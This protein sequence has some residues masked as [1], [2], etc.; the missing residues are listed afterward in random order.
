M[1]NAKIRG[2]DVWADLGEQGH[3]TKQDIQ[4]S[5]FYSKVHN[6]FAYLPH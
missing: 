1:N 6:C 3:D 4:V 5:C 2:E